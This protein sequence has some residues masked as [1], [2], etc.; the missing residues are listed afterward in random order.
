MR[1][2]D[3]LFALLAHT[4]DTEKQLLVQVA[5]GNEAAF[6][7][8]YYCH[9]QALGTYIFQLTAS[10]ELAEEIV[11]DTFLK[12][13]TDRQ[14][15]ATV[16][17]FKAWLFI[18]SKNHALNTLRK[19]VRERA[20]QKQWQ[21]EHATDTATDMA[22]AETP[23]YAVLE[24]AIRN[25]PAQ[26]KKVFILSRFHHLKY[27]E[28]ASELNISRET[29]KSYLRNAADSIA[30]YISKRSLFLWALCITWF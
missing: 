15:L 23:S 18:V 7:Q 20:L 2:N 28:I 9:H 14:S 16:N 5:E 12:I 19:I 1:Y 4:P 27:R 6:R 17:N 8:L 30:R 21:K 29:V 11:Q 24:Q 10:R 13:W 3:Q 26:Q 22:P 25:L